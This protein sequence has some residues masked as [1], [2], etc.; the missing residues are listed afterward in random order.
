M[1]RNYPDALAAYA[2]ALR[3]RPQYPQALEYLGETYVAMG[4]LDDARGTLAKLKPLDAA[5]ADKLA[6]AIDGGAPAAGW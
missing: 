2:E 3:L 5:L 4:K 6:H 1:Q